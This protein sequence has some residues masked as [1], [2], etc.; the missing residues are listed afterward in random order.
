ME[1]DLTQYKLVKERQDNNAIT[2]TYQK[3]LVRCFACLKQVVYKKITQ[4]RYPVIV[5]GMGRV[6]LAKDCCDSCYDDVM[7]IKDNLKYN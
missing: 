3:K 6:I 1:I 5:K 7:T 4:V 2:I